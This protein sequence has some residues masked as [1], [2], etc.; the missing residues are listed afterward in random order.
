MSAFTR[1][2]ARQWAASDPR[3]SAFVVAN[4]GSGKTHVL[5]SRVVRLLLDGAD[6]GAVLCLTFT[7]AAAAEMARR[8]FDTLGLWAT[9][10]DDGLKAAIQDMGG[11]PPSAAHLRDARRLF[12]RALETPGGLKIQTIHAFCERLLHQFPFEANVPAHFS[13]LDDAQGAALNREARAQV[14]GEARDARTSL[15]RAVRTLAANA[16][17]GA[18]ETALDCVLRDREA[19]A[20]WV[21]S[22]G[23][24]GRTG[25]VEDALADLRK[26]LSLQPGDD[27]RALAQLYAG[28]NRLRLAEQRRRDLLERLRAYPGARNDA[29]A[30]S[31]EAFEAAEDPAAR[32]AALYDIYLTKAL[33]PRKPGGW[34]TKAVADGIGDFEECFEHDAALCLEAIERQRALATLEATEALLIV[35][36][37]ILE[38]YAELKVRAGSLDYDDLIARARDLVS[39]SDAAQWVLYKLDPGIR[40]ILVDEAQDT[41]PAQWAIVKALAQEFFS[42]NGAAPAGRTIFA[43]GDDKQSIYGFQGAEPR[44]MAEMEAH[45]RRA[46]HGIG[47]DF[48]A[49]PLFLSFRSAP[50][51]LKAVDLVFEGERAARVS[52]SCYEA[53]SAHRREAPGRVVV[54]P[55]VVS[56]TLPPPEDWTAPFDTPSQAEV[57]LAE[58]IAGE[59]ERLVK[60]GRLPSG[61]PVRPGSVMVLTRK[62]GAFATA[63]NRALKSR[64]LPAAGSDRVALAEYIAV[65]DLLALADVTLLPEDD[66]QLAAV[67][68]SPLVGLFD[69][70]LLELAAGRG[71]KSLWEAL[72]AASE[73]RFTDAYAQLARWRAMA[74]FVTP[75]EFFA[76]VLG[77]GGG[78]RRIR[79]RLGAEADDVLDAFLSQ[80]AACEALEPPTLQGL[81]AHIRAREG[82]MKREVDEAAGAVR[83]LTV[84]GAK[85]LEAD[86]VFLADTGGAIAHPGQRGPLEQLDGRAIVWR[87]SGADAT[88]RQRAAEA[89]ADAEAECE[90]LRLLYVGMTR[91]ADLLYVC[92]I[93][94]ER[95]PEE[96]WHRTVE[97]AL[98]PED[99]GRDPETGEL[100]APYA[101]PP[102]PPPSPAVEEPPAAPEPAVAVPDWLHRPAAPPPETPRP[103]RPSRAL[104][105]PDPL[106]LDAEERARGRL[107]RRLLEALP[108]VEPARRREVAQELLAGEADAGERESAIAEALGVLAA[109]PFLFGPDS[110]GEVALAGAVP[111][112]SGPHAVSGR[113]DRLR[114]TQDEVHLVDFKTGPA[115]AGIEGADPAHVLQLALHRRLLGR[116]IRGRSVRAALLFTS[117]PTLIDIPE[118]AAEAALRGIGVLPDGALP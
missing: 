25:T 2:Q 27:A 40:H 18:I 28:S 51:I 115:P 114:V 38:R 97:R 110:R 70:D 26:R 42:G 87:R 61:K 85:G 17:D 80:V 20:A 79:A 23:P 86:V 13:V 65:L 15:G 76:R 111:T 21:A 93:R 1:T 104:A 98:V 7:R 53:H 95:T 46:A 102:E 66:L 4:A 49:A 83:V 62:R 71:E 5:T 59:I 116:I 35:G 45:F 108:A 3:S 81:I 113:I 94:G 112:G 58:D 74:D 69:N 90:H 52:V 105:E 32:L 29:A 118:D 30:A 109:F 88:A 8:I 55:R 64:R 68:V 43:V 39:R 67:L 99:A 9:L 10:P 31:L 117:G 106:D 75:F 24:R 12:G 57:R 89:A 19:L 73:P 37:A 107:V 82:D 63:M 60:S 34:I 78:R 6:P 48:V 77:P 91:A 14:L 16:P 44:M 103:L 92:G 47:A 33:E 41:S 11:S 100:A 50:E 36:D 84:H 22:C 96:C 54:W 101:W 72:R 56:R